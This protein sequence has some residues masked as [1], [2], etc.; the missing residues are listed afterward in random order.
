MTDGIT[1][2]AAASFVARDVGENGR[3]A[4]ELMTRARAAGARMIQFPEG[5]LSGY[6][7]S[8]FFDWAQVDWSALRDELDATAEHARRLGLWTVLGCNHRLTPPHRPHNSLYVVSD[9]GS[10][11]GRYDKQFCSNAEIEDWYSPGAEPLVFEVDGFKFGA[12]LCIEIFFPDLF[13]AYE[14]LGVDCVLFSTSG[15]GPAMKLLAR[16][17]AATNNYWMSLSCWARSDG[18]TA[19]LIGPDGEPFAESPSEGGEG[20]AIGALD[21]TEPRYDIALNKARPWRAAA[22]LGN[23]YEARRVDDVRSRDR[24]SF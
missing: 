20:L 24:S 22:R 1:I 13:A 6:P 7:K 19:T 5:A 11:V 9:A 3:R 2:A 16:A 10:V 17:H 14:R 12:A 21:R 18:E 23:I 4:R 8:Q 15:S